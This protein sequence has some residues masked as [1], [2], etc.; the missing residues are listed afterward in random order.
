MRYCQNCGKQIPDKTR[1]CEYCGAEQIL[2]NQQNSEMLKNGVSENRE[3][4]SLHI[5]CPQCKSDNIKYVMKGQENEGVAGWLGGT[6]GLA[7]YTSR[8]KNKYIWVCHDCGTTFPT[9]DEYQEKISHYLTAKSAAFVFAAIAFVI[10][11][12]LL[13]KGNMVAL[14]VPLISAIVFLLIGFVAKNK[15]ENLMVQ[16]VTLK[17]HCYN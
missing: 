4:N 11:V 3:N 17:N 6:L 14:V 15:A 10:A 5:H 2:I 16:M 12:I 1:Y 13:A 8:T 9:I 7:S